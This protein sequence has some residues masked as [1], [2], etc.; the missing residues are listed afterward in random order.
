MRSP[1]ATLEP[2]VDRQRWRLVDDLLQTVLEQPEEERDEYLRQACQGDRVLEREISELLRAGLDDSFLQPAGAQQGSVWDELLDEVGST[3]YGEEAETAALGGERIGPYRI[4]RQIGQGGMGTVFLAQRVG[5]SD[6]ELV[7]LKVLAPGLHDGSI[8]RRFEQERHI[9]AT[10]AHPAIA[11]HIDGGVADDGRPYLVMEYVDGQPI[12]RYCDHHQLTLE[13]RLQLFIEVAR[14]VQYAHR[15]MVVHRDLKPSNILVTEDGQ[16]KL[17]DFGIAKLLDHNDPAAPALELDPLTRTGLRVMT[18]EYAS[19]E[20]VRGGIITTATDV[21]Q[22][23][24]V[25]YELLSGRRPY[26]LESCTPAEIEAVICER[27]PTAPSVAV[28]RSDGGSA[29]TGGLS[30]EGVA[31][32]RRLRPERLQARLRGDLDTI[33]LKMLRKEPE[34]RYLSVDSLIQD[35]ERNRQGRPISARKDTVVY[36]ISRFVRRHRIGIGAAVAILMLSA[37]AIGLYIDRR[38][39]ELEQ[40]RR[41]AAQT[42][43]VAAF[44]EGLFDVAEPGSGA[45]VSAQEL[46]DHGVER[47]S[48]NLELQPQL[49]ATLQEL[50]GDMYRKLG[51]YEQARPLLE[52]ALATRRE[53]QGGLGIEV[54]DSL[55]TCA[56]LDL[57]TGRYDEAE[58]MLR[59]AIAIQQSQ[60]GKSSPEVARSQGNLAEVLVATGKLDEAELLYLQALQVHRGEPE[61]DR[62]E[63]AKTLIGLSSLYWS[64]GKLDEAEPQLQQALEILEGTS[65]QN[66]RLYAIALNDL[67]QLQAR[68]GQYDQAEQRLRRGHTVLEERLGPD[69]PD[70]AMS[71]KAIARLLAEQGELDQ[72]EPLFQ[73]A[74]TIL[75]EA[76]QGNHPDIAE[77]LH[78]IGLLYW[79]RGD[80]ATAEQMLQ[81]ALAMG[82]ATLGADHPDVAAGLNSLGALYWSLGRLAEAE[83]AYRRSLAVVEAAHE[84]GHPYVAVVLVNLANLLGEK[85]DLDAAIA[86]C[87]RAVAINEQTLGAGHVDVAFS[88]AVLARLYATCGSF[89]QA[90]PMLRLVLQVQEEAFGAGH[91]E[92]LGPLLQLG[93]VAADQGRYQEAISVY[94]RAAAIAGTLADDDPD[95]ADSQAGL[96]GALLRQGSSLQR[97]ESL[98]QQAIARIDRIFGPSSLELVPLHSRLAEVRL[99][100]GQTAKAEE[101]LELAL[102]TATAAQDRLTPNQLFDYA[103]T[104]LVLGRLQ[105]ESGR[106]NQANRSWLTAMQ[107]IGPYYR[108][109]CNLRWRRIAAMTLLCLGRREQARPL[110]EALQATGY[111]APDLEL[112]IGNSVLVDELKE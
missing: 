107:L 71:L 58:A 25:L 8:R 83:G 19:P 62:R 40:T 26:R 68:R 21:Y 30:P 99:R 100:Q 96:A 20:Q 9:L 22:L 67:G 48:G 102:E 38:L 44:L 72:A 51:S 31:K 55:N 101:V 37:I 12:D 53:I 66:Q 29:E 61:P 2:K 27:E 7:A 24:L 17:L 97:A 46:L 52:Q 32:N 50:L 43:Q 74:L 87:E 15:C 77:C 65:D 108:G 33:V 13:Q 28:R 76:H 45:T 18:P 84:P 11:R 81:Q 16:L 5:S 49:E 89:D 70:T 98:L 105:N 109:S 93:R 59:E 4:V 41:E 6:G 1:L 39:T 110:A 14:A 73:K 60:L 79:N 104:W 63:I 95:V 36:R 86:F 64:Q 80:Y 42:A 54:A 85:G 112:I 94:E 88:Q 103:E 34:R 82:E 10:L 90:E 35:L 91:P 92:L 69:H 75:R 3:E 78:D 111:V 23:G 56:R 47:I 57:D 106:V